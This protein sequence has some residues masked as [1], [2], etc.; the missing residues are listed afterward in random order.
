MTSKTISKKKKNAA[1]SKKRP[2]EVPATS[3]SEISNTTL[4]GAVNALL[5]RHKAQHAYVDLGSDGEKN[6]IRLVENDDKIFV[7]VSLIAPPLKPK[8]LPKRALLP[9][10]LYSE[11]DASVCLI[12]KDPVEDLSG[13]LSPYSGNS[14]LKVI[15][16]KSLRLGYKTHERRRALAQAHEVFLCDSRIVPSIPHLCGSW[17]TKAKKMPI[18]VDLSR[19]VQLKQAMQFLYTPIYVPAGNSASVHIGNVQM[20]KPQIIANLKAIQPRIQQ[21][22]HDHEIASFYIRSNQTP[23]LPL[24]VAK[25]QEIVETAVEED[26]PDKEMDRYIEEF[27][28]ETAVAEEE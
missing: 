4:S 6:P 17:F 10:G 9:H 7:Q 23:A 26:G 27:E 14:T 2:R 3:V 1:V 16:L 21:V 22:F 28:K 15:G 25:P 18:S 24:F 12:V 13:L 8:L 19:D 11:S 20:S 5:K